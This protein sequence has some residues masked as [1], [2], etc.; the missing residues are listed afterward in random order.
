M[1]GRIAGR[2][3]YRAEDHVLIDV[4]G[5]GYLVYCNERT[6]QALPG[7]RGGMWRSIPTCWCARTIMQ[8]FGFTSLVE[9]EWHRLLISV[10]GDRRQG[11]DGDPRAHWGLTVWAARLLWA[12]GIRSRPPRGSAPRR[13]K[14]RRQ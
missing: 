1:I 7:G 5:V 3:D 9:K 8:L 12:T 6:L 14:A 13:R 10:Q 4:R 11:V 2:V